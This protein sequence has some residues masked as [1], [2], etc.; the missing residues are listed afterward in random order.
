M[1]HNYVKN[2]LMLLKLKFRHKNKIIVDLM[3][4]RV[5]L[6]NKRISVKLFAAKQFKLMHF[7]KHN[8]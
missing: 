6:P 4:S 1:L 7:E 2:F 5:A 8:L 3:L